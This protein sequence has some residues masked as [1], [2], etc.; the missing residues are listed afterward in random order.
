MIENTPGTRG[1]SG[2]RNQTLALKRRKKPKNQFFLVKNKNYKQKCL[3]LYISSIYV[4]IWGKQNSRFVSFPEMGQ[5]QY[6]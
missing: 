4:N 5:M 3:L 6:T 2:F 1:G